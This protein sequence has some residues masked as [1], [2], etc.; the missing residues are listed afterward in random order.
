MPKYEPPEDLPPRVLRS[1]EMITACQE[2]DFATIFQLAKRAG[3]Y[4]ALIGRRC[5]MTPSRATEILDGKRQVE[6]LIVIERI[7]DGLRIP[8]HMLGLAR[9]AWEPTEEAFPD[10]PPR[11]GTLWDADTVDIAEAW[12]SDPDDESS[13]PEFVAEL[14]ES[15]LPQHYQGANFFGA[16]HSIP[17]VVHHAQTIARLLETAADDSRQ[18]LLRTGARTAEFIGWLHQDLGNFPAAAYWSNQSME[19]AQEADD[20]HMQAYLLFRKSNQATARASGQKTISLARAAQR[21]PFL[22]PQ[23]TALATQQE[24]QGHALMR[25]P[26]A[27]LAKFDEAHALAAQTAEVDPDTAVDTSYCTPA[28]IEIQRANCWIDLGEPQR[29]VQLFEDQLKALPTVYRNDRGVYLA[30]LARAHITAGEPDQG[31]EAATKALAIVAQTGSARTFAELETV[32]TAVQEQRSLS[33]V[34]TFFDRF[35]AIKDRFTA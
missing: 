12:P 30:R 18:A 5:Q 17:S 26:K 27:A 15:Q 29:A 21:F 25:N 11:T 3:V 4:P 14:I 7:A 9:R 34:A 6:R 10:T 24:A 1:A 16:R 19:W 8:G 20:E 31:A 35:E 23:L 22:T 33:E 2:R 13:D 28:Y 32:A